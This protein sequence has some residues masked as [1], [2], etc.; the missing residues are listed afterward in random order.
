MRQARKY[1]YCCQENETDTHVHVL[2]QGK[3]D[4]IVFTCI[5]ARKL[6]RLVFTCIAARKMRQNSIYMY[7]CQE[8]ETAGADPGFQVRGGRT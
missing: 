2:V 8:N 4:R 1:M 6:D 7:C 3:R 5:A